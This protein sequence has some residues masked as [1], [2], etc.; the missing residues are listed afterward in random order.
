MRYAQLMAQYCACYVTY[1]G[2][3]YAEGC[4]AAVED[5][6]ACLAALSCEE[7]MAEGAC[8]TQEAETDAICGAGGTTG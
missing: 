6:Y 5:L 2:S 1:Y 8:A 7:L 3:M 4:S